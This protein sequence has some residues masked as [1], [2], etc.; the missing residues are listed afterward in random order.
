MAGPGIFTRWGSAVDE[1]LRALL[2]VSAYEQ[3]TAPAEIDP[4]SERSVRD[5]MG[6]Q[7]SPM[8]LNQ[9]RWYLRDIEDA[10]RMSDGGDLQKVGE[11]CRAMRKDGMI[12]G[13]LDTRTEGLVRL[14][15]R[16]YG[17][18]E[19][20][21]ELKARNGTRSLFSEMFPPSELALLAGDGILAGVG[22]AELVPVQGRAF[23]VMI[24]RDPAW[25]RYRW[26]EGRWYFSAVQGQIPITPGDGRWILHTPCGREAPWQNAA[27]KALGRAFITKEHSWSMR[28]NYAAKLAN[29]ARVATSPTASTQ[30]QKVSWFEQVVNWGINTVFNVTPGYKVELLEIKGTGYK[31]FAEDMDAADH[32]IMICLAGQE[33][34]TTGGAGFSNM[35]LFRSIKADLI[36]ATGDGLAYTINT[37]G[38]P[39]WV[40]SSRGIDALDDRAIIE[41]D[42]AQPKDLNAEASSLQAIATAI[43]MLRRETR[44]DGRELD[45]EEM[46]NRFSVP[47]VMRVA[48]ANDARPATIDVE[49]EAFARVIDLAKSMGYQPSPEALNAMAS[50][51]G[52]ALVSLPA[53]ET[54]VAKLDLAPTDIAKVVRVDEVRASQGLPPMG[55]DRGQLTITQMDDPSAVAAALAPVDEATEQ[56]SVDPDGDGLPGEPPTVDSAQVLA[57]KMT[58][59]GVQRCEHGSTNRC[60]LCGVERDRDV[61]LDENGDAVWSV[62]WKPIG[63]EPSS[64]VTE[65]RAA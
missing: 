55:D 3:H 19:Q 1:R 32:E 39:P 37:Q 26:Q 6:G 29:P 21:A 43:Q 42:T 13:L 31:V 30:E 28:G 50:A 10:L 11:L 4:E 38:L 25:L 23:P 60:R 52:I 51:M 63:A 12:K 27:W 40:V 46:Y 7:I 62:K 16:Y 49:P 8:P 15:I 65:E 18:E 33:V 56:I 58:S 22:V 34:T 59:L 17:S 2:A 57:D 64:V 41:W 44:K 61:E 24:R 14:P 9:P 45:V 5:A 20:I 48:A 35:D 47:L 53:G 36:K 54:G